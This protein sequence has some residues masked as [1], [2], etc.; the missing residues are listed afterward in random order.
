MISAILKMSRP[1]NIVIASVT[2]IIGYYLIDAF[3]ASL[4]ETGHL[5]QW[6]LALQIL[7]FTFAIAF[8]NI[9]NDILDYKSDCLNQPKRPLPSNQIS[10]KQA[11][12]VATLFA[13][14]SIL[15]GV[16]DTIILLCT[17]KFSIII[18]LIPSFFFIILF[19][20]LFCYNVKLKHIPLLKNMMVAFLCSTPLILNWI[21]PTGNERSIGLLYPA[22][23]FAFLLTTTREILKDLEDETGDLVAGIMTFPLIAGSKMARNFALAILIFTWMLLPLPVIQGFYPM[24]FLILSAATL[25]P[26]FAIIIK[27]ANAKNYKKAQTLVKVSM[28]AG[29]VS[30]VAAKTCSIFS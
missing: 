30:L 22:M 15:C 5:T 28:F 2:L 18:S 8:A 16:F 10:T 1:V 21:Y 6:N 23:M 17:N 19:A 14:L 26:L 12:V 24:L 7:G 20:F 29:L 27:N 9:H 13:A 11:K 4:P 25:T 3:S